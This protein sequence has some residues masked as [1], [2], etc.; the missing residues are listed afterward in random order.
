MEPPTPVEKRVEPPALVRLEKVLPDLS[1]T[2]PSERADARAK[3]NEWTSS[4]ANFAELLKREG[5]KE[6]LILFVAAIKRERTD[7]PVRLKLLALLA[8]HAAVFGPCWDSSTTSGLV[9]GV[10]QYPTQ[11]PEDVFVFGADIL[12]VMLRA[13]ASPSL[14]AWMCDA[15][16]WPSARHALRTAQ[17]RPQCCIAMLNLCSVLVE[18]DLEQVKNG[19]CSSGTLVCAL[20][21][22][23]NCV[24]VAEQA[25]A[26]LPNATAGADVLVRSPAPAIL[27]LLHAAVQ[28]AREST[29]ELTRCASFS[30][31]LSLAR[32]LC[33]CS[34]PL[35]G[36]AGDLLLSACVLLLSLVRGKAAGQDSAGSKSSHVVV[37]RE[38]VRAALVQAGLP[39][40]CLSL[41]QVQADASRA[42]AVQQVA[43]AILDALTAGED[44][45]SNSSLSVQSS[46]LAA[47]EGAPR[48]PKLPSNSPLLALVLDPNAG[49]QGGMGASAGRTWHALVQAAL[50]GVKDGR[51]VDVALT[52]VSLLA[53]AGGSHEGVRILARA[54][55]VRPEGEGKDCGTLLAELFLACEPCSSDCLSPSPSTAV[56]RRLGPL[57]WLLAS[58]RARHTAEVSARRRAAWRMYR[59]QQASEESDED[60]SP[61][62]PRAAAKAPAPSTYSWST[63]GCW[64]CHRTACG[65]PYYEHTAL[66]SV[67]WARPDGESPS[68]VDQAMAIECPVEDDAAGL[69]LVQALQQGGYFKAGGEGA[70]GVLAPAL[71]PLRSPGAAR[72]EDRAAGKTWR[73]DDVIVRLSM[74]AV[75][76]ESLCDAAYLHPAGASHSQRESGE[77]EAMR[78][79][80]A[81]ED[82]QHW[83]VIKEQ[84]A[85]AEL[86]SFIRECT[87]SLEACRMR[88][89]S[90]GTCLYPAAPALVPNTHPL[91]GSRE[92]ESTAGTLSATASSESTDAMGRLASSGGPAFPLPLLVSQEMVASLA[93]CA[94][95]EQYTEVT[96]FAAWVIREAVTPAPPPTSSSGREWSE[97]EARM[98]E[99]APLQPLDLAV[100]QMRRRP[101]VGVVEVLP[102]FGW[103]LLSVP[104]LP[105]VPL[106]SSILSCVSTLPDGDASIAALASGTL[107]RAGIAALMASLQVQRGHVLQTLMMQQRA[108]ASCALVCSGKGEGGSAVHMGG[109]R[110]AGGKEGGTPITPPVAVLVNAVPSSDVEFY[111]PIGSSLLLPLFTQSWLSAQAAGVLVGV[112]SGQGQWGASAGLAALAGTLWQYPWCTALTAAQARDALEVCGAKVGLRA[113]MFRL[114]LLQPIAPPPVPLLS[115]A[116]TAVAAGG[117]LS[118]K[119]GVQTKAGVLGRLFSSPVK[120]AEPSSASLLSPS[121]TSAPGPGL[122]PPAGEVS[123]TSSRKVEQQDVERQLAIVDSKAGTWAMAL[124]VI[125]QSLL[126][127]TFSAEDAPAAAADTV[128]ASI[129]TGGAKDAFMRLK[130]KGEARR[131]AALAAKAAEVKNE[132][133]EGMGSASSG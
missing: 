41:L 53:R 104:L 25:A 6:V 113:T 14:K 78:E 32:Q 86:L 118:P 18:K 115:S 126:A 17:G 69:T 96:A 105:A 42:E 35:P 131:L 66:G 97:I 127:M 48:P 65:V 36:P 24:I 50:Q 22:L 52:V 44:A 3:F 133:T 60:G 58:E 125:Q 15:D 20:D 56:R 73:A 85:V 84:E 106:G 132:G 119:E 116:S 34:D 7:H 51:R 55:H 43:A 81:A 89:F 95:C 26:T 27:R 67:Q 28:S 21:L 23:S 5:N 92:G 11:Y 80:M 13:T 93:R 121:S 94:R 29:Q 123:S 100:M 98:M 61:A 83:P 114:K 38:Q 91:L 108:A 33:T 74:C 124:Y 75:A 1:S 45:R 122:G 37:D 39:S 71:S 101:R 30:S 117:L 10:L 87:A 130:A 62:A 88:G 19:L 12:Y 82:E 8:S 79:E 57:L 47:P 103:P 112:A 107:G 46:W 102:P 40:L 129:V 59:E 70:G 64:S 54:L 109:K 111:A 63:S 90:L 72:A 9:A 16:V 76:C 31:V 68:H 77:E 110:R 99:S 4:E 128:V 120:V 2:D 49:L